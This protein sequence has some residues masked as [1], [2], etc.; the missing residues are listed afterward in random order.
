[1]IVI[2]VLAADRIVVLIS[3]VYLLVDKDKR[4]V[5]TSQLGGTGC[6]E[7]WVLLWWAGL[8]SVKL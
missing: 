2:L 8:S 4:L 7:N 1:M 6:G 5:Q 3:S